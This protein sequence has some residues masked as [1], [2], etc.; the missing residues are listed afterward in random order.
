MCESISGGGVLLLTRATPLDFASDDA[1]SAQARALARLTGAAEADVLQRLRERSRRLAP[2]EKNFDPDIADVLELLLETE[3]PITRGREIERW[4]RF[5]V[6]SPTEQRPAAEQPASDVAD[7]AEA[8]GRYESM[9]AEQLIALLHEYLPEIVRADSSSLPA[10]DEHFYR[11]D[12]PKHFERRHIDSDL[13]PAV[14]GCLGMLLVKHL[15]GRWVPRQNLDETAVIV[16]DRAWLPFLRAR[17]YLASKDSV[18]TH[19]LT[20]LYRAAARR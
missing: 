3:L 14:G 5:R 8:I 7:A 11:G 17:H 12:Y 10:V 9:Y 13:V 18:L 1:R 6:P 20:Q 2:V 4:N 16:G 15:G 19:S